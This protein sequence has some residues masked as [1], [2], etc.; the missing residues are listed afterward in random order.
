MRRHLAQRYTKFVRPEG[1]HDATFMKLLREYYV[2]PD[3]SVEI[4]KDRAR[5]QVT[6]VREAIQREG[7]FDERIVVMDGDVAQE[8]MTQANELAKGKVEV[9]R[10]VPCIE[11]VLIKILEPKKK[12][13]GWT[14]QALKDYFEGKYIPQEKRTDLNTYRRKFPKK[15][16]DEARQR[17]PELDRMIKV[18]EEKNKI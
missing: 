17:V 1:P 10:N 5:D 15:M 13:N 6:M 18:I 7:A 4:K 16:L 8:E 9:V 11:A 14:S 2:V 3:I 12:I